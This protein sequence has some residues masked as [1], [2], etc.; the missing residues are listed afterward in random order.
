[1]KKPLSFVEISSSNLI[2][3]YKYLSKKSGLPIA[4]VLKSNAYGHGLI[5]VARVLEKQKPPFFCLDSFYEANLLNKA[6][7][8]TPILIMG[9]VDPSDLTEKNLP[10]SYAVW[11]SEQIKEISAKDP[12]AKFHIFVDTGMHRE[13]VRMDD[14]AS[15]LSEIK[16]YSGKIEG[17]MSH[18]GSAGDKNIVPQKNK[19][20]ILAEHRSYLPKREL[21]QNG[22]T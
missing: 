10:F 4:P 12:K 21:N 13:G 19:L 6:G 8:K 7:L 16:A 9:Y 17:L 5:E 15:F 18:F 14:L 2:H 1:M 22:F 11:S 20:R 3:N